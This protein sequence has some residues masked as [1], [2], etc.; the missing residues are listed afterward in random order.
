MAGNQKLPVWH[1]VRANVFA[2][3]CHPPTTFTVKAN[4]GTNVA[5]IISNGLCSCHDTEKKKSMTDIWF[6]IWA[7][8]R[9]P[10]RKW[11]SSHLLNRQVRRLQEG[12]PHE[13]RMFLHPKGNL[14]LRITRPKEA[15]APSPKKNLCNLAQ[16]CTMMVCFLTV[17]VNECEKQGYSSTCQ[18]WWQAWCNV[19]IYALQKHGSACLLSSARPTGFCGTGKASPLSCPLPSRAKLSHSMVNSTYKNL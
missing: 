4:A 5:T 13:D 1:V 10:R 12:S 8:G 18:Y 7:Q 9:P 16:N 6:Q 14:W 3:W 17:V 11:N 19:W 15:K 2:R